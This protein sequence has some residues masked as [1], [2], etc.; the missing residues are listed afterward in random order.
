MWMAPL[1]HSHYLHVLIYTQLHTFTHICTFVALCVAAA[2]AVFR[3]VTDLDEVGGPPWGWRPLHTD[4]TFMSLGAK[5]STT[6]SDTTTIPIVFSCVVAA[7]RLV[8]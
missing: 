8:L 1:A 3:V 2:C 7:S 4:A 6:S 5:W